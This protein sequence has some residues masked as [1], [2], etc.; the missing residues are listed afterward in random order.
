LKINTIILFV[1]LLVLY[2]STANVTPTINFNLNR[3]SK[4]P[5][6]VNAFVFGPAGQTALSLDY[7][8]KQKFNV[9]IGMGAEKLFEEIRYNYFLGAKY[10]LFGKSI[11][12]TT[13]YLGIFDRVN[14]QDSAINHALY[15]PLDINRIFKNRINMS[16][17][18]AYQPF[19]GYNINSKLWAGFK[20]GYR[21]K[22]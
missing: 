9:E 13:F 15:C 14:F 22:K 4:Y 7:F 10:H 5:F 18:L 21:F 17:E 12:N 11:A 19:N 1:F 2:E 8:I 3:R 20:I 6:G 16:L